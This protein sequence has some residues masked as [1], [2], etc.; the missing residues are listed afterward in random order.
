MRPAM[1]AWSVAL[2]TAV[3]PVS[4]RAQDP[5][6]EPAVQD[7]LS[8][9]EDCWQDEDTVVS[10][11]RHRRQSDG[12]NPY[13]REVREE[14]H[15]RRRGNLWATGSLGLGGEAIAAPGS[16]TPWG[17]SRTAP[18]LS[19]G[20]GGTLSQSFRLGI[21]GFAWFKP[22]NNNLES[23]T[24]LMVTGRL[25][26][27]AKSGLYLKSGVGF[28]RYGVDE[29]DDCGCGN[30]SLVSD[31]GLAWSV[32]AG[33]EAPVSHGLS[34]GPVVEITR[35]NVSGPDGYRERVVNFGISLTF[36]GAD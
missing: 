16:V 18:T 26:P 12:D 21:E 17:Q 15:S 24:T 14:S 25:Y 3:A 22:G 30:Y 13:L 11:P 8:D 7:S 10:E 6:D 20:I 19:F 35:M 33:F 29:F 1:L 9:D 2:L 4:L 36:D 34:I 23:V 31:Y 27:L 32:G 5:A 28:G